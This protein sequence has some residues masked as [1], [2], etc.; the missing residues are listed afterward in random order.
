MYVVVAPAKPIGGPSLDAAPVSSEAAAKPAPD[1]AP[2]NAK[3][4]DANA[5]APNANGDSRRRPRRERKVIS[6]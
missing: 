6:L 3:G 5:N 1:A 4:K 2:E